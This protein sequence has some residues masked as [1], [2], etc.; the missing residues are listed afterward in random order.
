MGIFDSHSVFD[1]NLDGKTSWYE[2]MVAHRNLAD[3]EQ[4]EERQRTQLEQEQKDAEHEDELAELQLENDDLRTDRVRSA[5]MQHERRQLEVYACLAAPVR[6]VG[7][8][9]EQARILTL[10][11]KWLRTFAK[12]F[13]DMTVEK[14]LD[15][16]DEFAEHSDA[17]Y[18]KL[19]QTQQ[20]LNE[21]K[22]ELER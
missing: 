19:Q 22:K 11:L 6:Q 3:R 2:F 7:E 12:D 10:E 18:R 13:P 8:C 15:L 1:W 16:C 9:N 21:A 17:L 14:L 20:R 5:Q 4:E